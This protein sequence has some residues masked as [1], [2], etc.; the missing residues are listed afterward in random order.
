MLPAIVV[1]H[2]WVAEAQK[3]PMTRL[4][5][6][7]DQ[8]LTQESGKDIQVQVRPGQKCLGGR[9]FQPVTPF[10]FRCS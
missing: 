4:A 5:E 10:P 3:M 9:V 8:Q 1:F 2:L 7:N 6:F